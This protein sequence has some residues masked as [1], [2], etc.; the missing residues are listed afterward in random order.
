MSIFADFQPHIKGKPLDG[1]TY[2]LA[3]EGDAADIAGI[4]FQREGVKKKKDFNYYLERTTKELKNIESAQ[5]F[6][7]IVSEYKKEII[8][9]GRSIYY[10]LKK[11]QVTYPAPS[12]WYLM[13][14]VVKPEFR[15]H[16]IGQYLTKERL[17][18]I[19]KNSKEAYYVVNSHNKTSIELHKKLGFKK[20]DEGEGF[21][22]I[23]FDSGKGYLFKICLDPHLDYTA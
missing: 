14:V 10:D 13:G 12:G 23:K 21:L 16:G 15:R 20:I 7:L 19:S 1:V 3:F 5:D 2:R 8:G 9:F 18:R 6:H 4:T 22:N 17:I 11:I